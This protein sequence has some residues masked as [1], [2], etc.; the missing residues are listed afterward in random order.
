MKNIQLYFCYTD[1]TGTKHDNRLSYE[2]YM[3]NIA[4]SKTTMVIQS[5]DQS[6]FSVH[7]FVEAVSVGCLPIVFSAMHEVGFAGF[8]DTNEF[9]AKHLYIDDLTE[10]QQTIDR[11]E[12]NHQQLL[13]DLLQTSYFKYL[14]KQTSESSLIYYNKI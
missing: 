9:I 11:L 10:L 3:K 1:K 14:K 2:E 8:T 5:Y 13:D 12:I 7:R 4:S 6:T